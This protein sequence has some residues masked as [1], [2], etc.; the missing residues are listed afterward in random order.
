[1]RKERIEWNEEKV[2]WDVKIK[3]KK[4]RRRRQYGEASLE[5]RMSDEE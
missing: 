4:R 5:D 3:K 2:G 1:M